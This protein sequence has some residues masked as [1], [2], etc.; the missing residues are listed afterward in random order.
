MNFFM[1]KRKSRIYYT[2]FVQYTNEFPSFICPKEEDRF[3]TVYEQLQYNRPDFLDQEQV[4]K[5]NF[6]EKLFVFTTLRNM[7]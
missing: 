6:S 7:A 5:V 2:P 3:I 4:L 1:L